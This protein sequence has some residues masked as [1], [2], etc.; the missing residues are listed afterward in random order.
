MHLRSASLYAPRACPSPKARI[1]QPIPV[2][3]DPV[4]TVVDAV[5]AIGRFCDSHAA[6]KRGAGLDQHGGESSSLSRAS[7]QNAFQLVVRDLS[8]VFLTRF[9]QEAGRMGPECADGMPS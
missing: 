7:H 1:A 6:G 5:E 8:R 4:D 3:T 2:G 9:R